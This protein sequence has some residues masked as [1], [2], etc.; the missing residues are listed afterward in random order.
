MVYTYRNENLGVIMQTVYFTTKAASK[1]SEYVTYIF[2]GS[3]RN[4]LE[5]IF[6]DKN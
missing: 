6:D 2:P 3:S 1:R 5:K 4:M